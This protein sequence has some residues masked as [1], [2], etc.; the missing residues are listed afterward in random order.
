MDLNIEPAVVMQVEAPVVPFGLPHIPGLGPKWTKVLLIAS[1]VITI[2]SI[3]VFVLFAVLVNNKQFQQKHNLPIPGQTSGSTKSAA[4][5]P[6]GGIATG[7]KGVCTGTNCPVVTITAEPAS[8]NVGQTVTI[9]WSVTNN[10]IKCTASQDWSGDK[11][12]SG[13]EKSPVLSKEDTY[14]FI[15]TCQTKEGGTGHN[16][17]SVSAV[18]H[19]TT[20]GGGNSPVLSF[21]VDNASPYAG[22]EVNLIWATSNYPTSCVASG[23]WS[24][25]K[26]GTS[27]QAVKVDTAGKKYAF[28]LKCSNS[29]GSDSVTVYVTPTQPP[30]DLPI[31]GLASNANGSVTPGSSVILTWG[32][33][34]N[35]DH[36]T[37]SGDNPS[38]TWNGNITPATGGSKTVGPLPSIQDYNF[39]L[40]CYGT[41]GS[42]YDTVAVKVLPNAPGVNLSLNKSSMNVGTVSD[43]AHTAILT[44]S[45]T[46]NPTTCT[47][48][49]WS[50]GANS[51]SATAKSV[52]LGP[53]NLS[54]STTYLYSLSCTN[55]GGTGFI[56][57]VRLDVV[58]PPAPNPTISVTIGGNVVSSTTTNTAVSVNWNAN[59][60]SATC[61]S[62]GSGWAAA[63]KAASGSSSLSFASTGNYTFTI[64]CTNDGG[65]NSASTS[66]TVNAPG[67]VSPAPTITTFNAS[68][69][70]TTGNPLQVN[71]GVAVSLSLVTTGAPVC[72]IVS[73]TAP[74]WASP[75]Q[76]KGQGG[77]IALGAFTV[78]TDTTYVFNATCTNGT[79]PDATA[80]VTV[81]VKAPPVI[82]NFSFSTNPVAS[83]SNTTLT[84]AAV[85]NMT[86]VTNCTS[87]GSAGSGWQTTANRTAAGSSVTINITNTGSSN[88]SYDY[89][90]NCTNSY[91]LSASKTVT[92]TVTPATFCNGKTGTCYG[93]AD[94][95]AHSTSGACW[96]WFGQDSSPGS[97][98]SYKVVNLN[99]FSPVHASNHGASNIVAT[100]SS[101]IAKTCG[102]DLTSALSGQNARGFNHAS[103]TK[104]GT[105]TEYRNYLIGFYDPLKP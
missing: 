20:G 51:P 101:G 85:A 64:S 39:T 89:T 47:P 92:L 27:T 57:N 77:T 25:T 67:T 59:D 11:A 99:S 48:T 58:K 78:T 36:C 84:W 52:T 72:T 44:Y 29:S 68:N 96:G 63:S 15:L 22:Q 8:V 86:G 100:A 28:T 32:V 87:T 38:G 88:A 105:N 4:A 19:L 34:G 31:T 73:P 3:L 50:Y 74:G 54:A 40:T 91:G 69:G 62:S 7:H 2:V 71:S 65:S 102:V 30:P 70:T 13:S 6:G 83:G 55:Q 12:A 10:P 94:L 35:P 82:G 53:F 26:P 37:A 56:N 43:S 80:S 61:S 41:G 76:Q 17:V 46:N 33:S 98:P 79:A 93:V 103:S 95:A 42:T 90:L 60:S 9:K 66:L 14:I 23:D 45:A 104:Q 18:N 49:G 97:P 5:L 21:S 24:G 75:G 81:N 1:A 16:E